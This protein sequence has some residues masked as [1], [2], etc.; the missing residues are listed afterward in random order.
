MGTASAIRGDDVTNNMLVPSLMGAN[1]R[2]NRYMVGD[3]TGEIEMV[4]AN[5]API[6]NPDIE[7]TNGVIQGMDYMI[8]PPIGDA[9]DA[10]LYDPQFSTLVTAL[11]TAELVDTLRGEGPFTILPPT[12]EAFAKIDNL[13]EI[14]EDKELLTSILLYHVVPDAR[15]S[16][17]YSP[18]NTLETVQGSAV[19]ITYTDEGELMV[20]GAMVE[21]VYRD[22]SATNAVVQMIDTVLL[23]PT[24][25]IPEK[26]LEL[27]LTTLVDLVTRA[28][29]GGALSGPG[30]LTVL[31][32]ANEAFT[33]E[34][35][36][37]EVLDFILGNDTALAEVLKYHVTASA[38]RGDDVTNNMLVPS[39][40]G[41]NVRLNR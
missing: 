41:A 27:G 23:P 31:A 30:P 28:G 19:R 17:S 36:P 26:A 11:V 21:P 4:T 37:Q 25:N 14:L 20:N 8:Y 33:P 7:A 5:G 13:D 24:A 35:F 32:P 38:I 34:R 10:A 29:L 39:L 40:M 18:G 9:V 2:L 15:Y 1:V 6:M 16:I 22:W 3:S 12:N